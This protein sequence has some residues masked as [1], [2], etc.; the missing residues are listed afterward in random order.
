MSGNPP[1]TDRMEEIKLSETVAFTGN[2]VREVAIT[3]D[4][5]TCI[6]F[7]KTRAGKPVTILSQAIVAI[8]DEPDDRPEHIIVLAIHE[9]AR[10]LSA[11]AEQG[12]TPIRARAIFDGA[13]WE[14]LSLLNSC[15][16]AA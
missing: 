2:R 16:E 6:S 11:L 9:N 10:R 14:I 12:E 5:H 15:G 1:E 7:G 8:V 3:T 13:C 4:Q